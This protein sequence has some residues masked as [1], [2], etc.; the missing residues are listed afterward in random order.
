MKHDKEERSF[1]KNWWRILGLFAF[2]CWIL[3]HLLQFSRW[4]VSG[5]ELIFWMAVAAVAAYSM[6]KEKG[7]DEKKK[8]IKG[9]VSDKLKTVIKN[10]GE[11]NYIDQHSLNAINTNVRQDNIELFEDR[12]EKI[13]EDISIK[14]EEAQEELEEDI[15]W[16]I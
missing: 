1:K 7:I 14:I 15:D 10:I 13:K 16:N 3:Y 8:E 5:L 2:A 11:T 6:G 4:H 12:I 9:M